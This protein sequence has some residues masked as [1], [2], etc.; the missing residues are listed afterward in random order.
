MCPHGDRG[1]RLLQLRLRQPMW[2]N[3]HGNLIINPLPDAGNKLIAINDDGTSKA[4]VQFVEFFHYGW[5]T[6]C[7]A[8]LRPIEKEEELLVDYGPDYWRVHN[9]LFSR[10]TSGHRSTSC[11]YR[12]SEKDNG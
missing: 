8:T 12:G 1:A 11:C 5:P 2:Q 10:S 7:M 6:V 4:N 9:I 3:Q